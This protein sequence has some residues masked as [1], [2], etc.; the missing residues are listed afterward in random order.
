MKNNPATRADLRKRVSESPVL[1]RSQKYEFMETLYLLQEDEIKMRTD[2]PE[3]RIRRE[4]EVQG[5]LANIVR[6]LEQ[7]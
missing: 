1:R 6:A 7:G 5:Q 2:S 4:T 3:N